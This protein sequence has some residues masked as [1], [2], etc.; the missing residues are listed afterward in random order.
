MGGAFAALGSGALFAGGAF[1]ALETGALFAGGALASTPC[2]KVCARAASVN[3]DKIKTMPTMNDKRARD[4]YFSFCF[5]F[6]NAYLKFNFNFYTLNACNN[7]PTYYRFTPC[8]M[9]MT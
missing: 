4:I 1:A 9:R 7:A 2:G 5:N 6:M 8:A 3:E